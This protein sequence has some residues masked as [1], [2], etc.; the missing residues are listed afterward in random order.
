MY[1]D[2]YIAFLDG[3]TD[4]DGFPKLVENRHPQQ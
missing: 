2:V 1:L 4:Q 3:T